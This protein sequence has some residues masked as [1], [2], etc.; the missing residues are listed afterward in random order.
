MSR[1]VLY[2]SVMTPEKIVQSVRE[3]L[4]ENADT[5]KARAGQRYFKEEVKMYGLSPKATKEIVRGLKK[6][7]KLL[8]TTEVYEIGEE[9]FK[10]GYSEEAW[11]ASEFCLLKRNDYQEN[12]FAIF[13]RWVHNYINNWASCD[14]FCN[15]SLASFIEKY[16]QFVEELKKWAESENR[17]VRRASAVTLIAPARQGKFAKDILEIADLLLLD[18]DDLVQKGYGWMLKALADFDQ[19]QVFDFVM[20][21]KDRMP[22]TA[23]RYA[24]EKMPKELK[25]KA[26]AK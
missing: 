1:E 6:E 25:M 20:A 24:I 10:S 23:L 12:D 15:H 17:W 2:N 9:L 11:I 4:R 26:M 7:I 18:N 19:M 8:T 5:T 3:Q 16:P 22:R 14:T 13:S 21:R